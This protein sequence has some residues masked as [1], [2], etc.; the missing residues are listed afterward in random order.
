MPTLLCERARE[1]RLGLLRGCWE[2]GAGRGVAAVPVVGV[3]TEVSATARE[4]PL[5]EESLSLV[6]PPVPVVELPSPSVPPVPS[7]SVDPP[8]RA[9]WD[10]ASSGASAPL[11]DDANAHKDRED[12]PDDGLVAAVEPVDSEEEEAEEEEIDNQ[13]NIMQYFQ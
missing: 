1:T 10:A 6:S 2:G 13:N 9:M 12:G 4:L 5:E 3:G 8:F 7:S 11:P